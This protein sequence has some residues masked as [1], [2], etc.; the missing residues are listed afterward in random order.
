MAEEV[1]SA[2]QE[3]ADE[4]PD[5]IKKITKLMIKTTFI[6]KATNSWVLKEK[7]KYQMPVFWLYNKK[8]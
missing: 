1:A 3:A 6:Y 2:H 8:P 7:D 4:F 5:T